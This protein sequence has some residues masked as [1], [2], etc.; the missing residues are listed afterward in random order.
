MI[1]NV[2]TGITIESLVQLA[3]RVR[4]PIHN[5]VIAMV[6]KKKTNDYAADITA[7]EL[8]RNRNRHIVN[9]TQCVFPV[10]S[11]QPLPLTNDHQPDEMAPFPNPIQMNRSLMR[12]PGVSETDTRFTAGQTRPLQIQPNI[13]L[14][15]TEFNE[16]TGEIE[17][18]PYAGKF[19][20]VFEPTPLS[21]LQAAV[22]FQL[23][24]H[25][26]DSESFL[27]AMM[28]VV[29]QAGA[30]I[31]EVG[32]RSVTNAEGK[33][34]SLGL[35]SSY[36][37][38]LGKRNRESNPEKEDKDYK[39][40]ANDP[41][42]LALDDIPDIDY[43]NTLRK[44]LYR[45]DT[46]STTRLTRLRYIL[47]GFSTD[48]TEDK[49][50]EQIR[51]DVRALFAIPADI[52]P[53]PLKINTAAIPRATLNHKITIAE[54]YSCL[55]GLLN[56]LGWKMTEGGHIEAPDFCTLVFRDGTPE[57]QQAF[58]SMVQNVFHVFRKEGYAWQY[59]FQTLIREP[60]VPTSADGHSIVFSHLQ[61]MLAFVGIPVKSAKQRPNNR[62]NKRVFLKISLDKPLFDLHLA[63]LGYN[64]E[65][66]AKQ[67]PAEALACYCEK[68]PREEE[69]Q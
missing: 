62:G 46:T 2:K 13:A 36:L 16:E 18:H 8:K 48:A 65:T 45:S 44:L 5:K 34:I 53:I 7:D 4:S 28:Q 1:G 56:L 31:A 50:C 22:D 69:A 52:T 24:S 35:H 6:L 30:G 19:G 29:T 33:D 17:Y 23:Y 10:W 21:N 11:Q 67:T 61:Q 68:Y 39:K 40:R 55:I 32:S 57:V 41:L 20:I 64:P 37:K 43:A 14:A 51:K 12:D 42:L 38:N 49:L 63:L 54:A 25:S 59:K 47:S 58:W 9:Y 60:N 27:Q 15:P 66:L 26:A 3:G